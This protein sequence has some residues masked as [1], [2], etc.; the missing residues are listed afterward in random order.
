[1][2]DLS[3]FDIYDYVEGVLLELESLNK[4]DKFLCSVIL[5]SFLYDKTLSKKTGIVIAKKLLLR[6]EK[7]IS[8]DNLEFCYCGKDYINP[9]KII[10]KK[11]QLFYINKAFNIIPDYLKKIIDLCL[12]QDHDFLFVA[13]YL[14]ESI[15][16]IKRL[17]YLGISLVKYFFIKYYYISYCLTNEWCL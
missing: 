13:N 11:E 6:E 9:F 7:T 12:F 3:F 8:F 5:D 15:I 1:M 4:N 17:Y 2:D 16:D 10:I 14:N